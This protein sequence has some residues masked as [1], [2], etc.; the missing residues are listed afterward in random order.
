MSL[1]RIQ[2]PLVGGALDGYLN[3]LNVKQLLVNGLPITPTPVLYGTTLTHYTQG[4]VL[5]GQVITSTDSLSPPAVPL[6][7][8]VTGDVPFSE[9]LVPDAIDTALKSGLY[10]NGYLDIWGTINIYGAQSLL[11]GQYPIVRLYCVANRSVETPVTFSATDSYVTLSLPPTTQP[12][13]TYGNTYSYKFTLK[14]NSDLFPPP[15]PEGD[16]PNI[17]QLWIQHV[18]TTAGYTVNITG[19]AA[20]PRFANVINFKLYN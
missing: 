2:E 4:L 15:D 12:T 9:V 10:D 11:G 20:N 19:E 8:D 17:I 14:Y 7:F 6:L 1:A 16:I 3:S 5:N 18:S 13:G